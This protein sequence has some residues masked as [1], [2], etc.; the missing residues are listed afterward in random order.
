MVAMPALKAATGSPGGRTTPST[1]TVPD[2]GTT[3]PDTHLMS[4]DLPAPF[5]P[6]RQWTWP[7][8]TTRSTP[9]SAFAPG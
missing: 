4:V 5:W 9:W 3:A 1:V 7:A 6:T 8:S 2:V